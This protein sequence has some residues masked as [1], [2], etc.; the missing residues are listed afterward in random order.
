MAL[1]QHTRRAQLPLG[2]APFCAPSSEGET[3]PPFPEGWRPASKWWQLKEGAP[4]KLLF[5]DGWK[6][7]RGRKPISRK[8]NGIYVHLPD[9]G[10]LEVFEAGIVL[11]SE[12]RP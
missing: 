9:G 4:C 11:I 6:D 2:V 10:T 12:E 1:N 8:A 5:P 3:R 7:A